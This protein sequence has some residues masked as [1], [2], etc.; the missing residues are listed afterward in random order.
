MRCALAIESIKNSFKNR[1]KPCFNE[2][3]NDF[4]SGL[5]RSCSAAVTS[6]ER[7]KAWPQAL[8]VFGASKERTTVSYNA[9][10]SACGAQWRRASGLLREE[11]AERHFDPKAQILIDLK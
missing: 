7:Q 5:Q 1:Q 6:C 2:I 11:W 9:A 3:F 4:W 8:A 10:I